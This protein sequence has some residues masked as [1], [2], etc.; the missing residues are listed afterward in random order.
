MEDD[1]IDKNLDN[2]DYVPINIQYVQNEE[3]SKV[4][5]DYYNFGDCTDRQ[6][7]NIEKN[8]KADPYKWNDYITERLEAKREYLKNKQKF[9]QKSILVNPQL[10]EDNKKQKSLHKQK[11][12]SSKQL[13]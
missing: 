5:D 8:E 4:L 3:K 1:L 13:K 11:V 6:Q 12:R 7:I 2:N 10:P 9:K